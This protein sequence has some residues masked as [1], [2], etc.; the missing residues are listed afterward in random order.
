MPEE[1]KGGHTVTWFLFCFYAAGFVLYLMV[2]SV[3]R[4]SANARTGPGAWDMSD[5]TAFAVATCLIWP[6]IT[7]GWVAGTFLSK[8][9]NW[10]VH[11][12]TLR[13]QRVIID[14][15]SLRDRMAKLEEENA[16]LRASAPARDYRTLAGKKEE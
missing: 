15:E 7:I 1:E 10:Y 9:G 12:A 14:T 16:I 11:R 4:A 8:F 13:A 3:Y 5:W 6:V 2:I